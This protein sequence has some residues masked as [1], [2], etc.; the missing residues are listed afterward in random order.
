MAVRTGLEDVGSDLLHTPKPGALTTRWLKMKQAWTLFDLCVVFYIPLSERMCHL[1]HPIQFKCRQVC[2]SVIEWL[3]KVPSL[4]F[5][6]LPHLV[7]GRKFGWNNLNLPTLKL[8]TNLSFKS[9]KLPNLSSKSTSRLACIVVSQI[10]YFMTSFEIV[11]VDDENGASYRGACPFVCLRRSSTWIWSGPVFALPSFGTFII[12]II[13]A[14]KSILETH[15]KKVNHQWLSVDRGLFDQYQSEE[16]RIEE[17][18]AFLVF[19]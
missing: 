19:S 14:S 4:G 18:L 1:L 8:V 11:A 9:T 5:A 17:S 16:T 7:A 3:A 10:M 2:L 13:I 15:Q 6:E 12:I